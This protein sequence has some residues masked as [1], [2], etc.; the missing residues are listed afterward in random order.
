MNTPDS[1]AER[2]VDMS[3]DDDD[4]P[5]YED[6]ED[7]GWDDDEEDEEDMAT[8]YPDSYYGL[9]LVAHG[10]LCCGVKTIYGF[11]CSPESKLAAL[12]ACPADNRDTYGNYVHSNDR[13][14][15]DAAPEETYLER[16][17]RYL[18]FLEKKR[19]KGL[20][21][22]T[23]TTSQLCVW[24]NL[25]RK[26]GFK[27]VTTFVNSNSGNTVV[28]LHKTYGQPPKVKKPKVTDPFA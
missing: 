2:P 3:H 21:E 6:F 7:R 19:P 27:K 14:F 16:L 8:Q 10:G 11:T 25:L 18:A 13:F 24:G 22:V 17:D 9:R 4:M 12:Q 20:V 28:V 23:L 5:E 26:R 15:N 1:Q